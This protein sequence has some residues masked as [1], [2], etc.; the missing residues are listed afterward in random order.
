MITVG[1][2]DFI[3]TTY[4]E[5]VIAIFTMILSC[6]IFAYSMNTI[7]SIIKN[8]N[9]SELII[10]RNIHIINSY[11][12]KKNINQKTQGAIRQYLE[13]YWKEESNRDSKSEEKIINQ[14]S[15]NLKQILQFESNNIIFKKSSI[16]R[17]NFSSDLK[18][19]IIPLIKEHRATP[20]ELICTENNEDDCSIY[21]LEKGSVE[22]VLLASS[23]NINQNKSNIVLSVGQSFGEIS[24]F[25]GKPRCMSIK[26][27]EFTTLLYIKRVDFLQIVK[28][29]PE[30]YE[31]FC[32]IKDN[33]DL[34]RQYSKL[35]IQCLSCKQLGHIVKDCPQ[36][37]FVHNQNK[38]RYQFLLC[39]LQE[40]KKQSR[41]LSQKF[42]TILNNQLIK[43]NAITLQTNYEIVEAYSSQSQTDY[44]TNEMHSPQSATD[45]QIKFQLDFD[46]LNENIT[47]VESPLKYLQRKAELNNTKTKSFTQFEDQKDIKIIEENM[48]SPF[49]Q[50][51]KNYLLQQTKENK[52]LINSQQEQYKELG[53]SD[54][55]LE[56]Q[57]DDNK[58]KQVQNLNKGI[59]LNKDY[60]FSTSKSSKIE[61][62]G[63]KLSNNIEKSFTLGSLQTNGKES[64]RKMKT[65]SDIQ[66]LNFI[67]NQITQLFLNENISNKYY[68]FNQSASI[69]S[70]QKQQE[71]KQYEKKFSNLKLNQTQTTDKMQQDL[72]QI[73]N[74][75]LSKNIQNEILFQDG[76][77]VAKNFLF[78]FPKNNIENLI[79]QI[80]KKQLK[81]T[82]NIK[83]PLETSLS[84]C[85]KSSIIFRKKK[86]STDNSGQN[87]LLQEDKERK[88]SKFWEN[89]FIYSDDLK[90]VKYL[91]NQE[92]FQAN[93]SLNQ[94]QKQ[95][96]KIQNKSILHTEQQISL[97]ESQLK[98]CSFSQ[99]QQELNKQD[100]LD[101]SISYLFKD[102]DFI[103]K[104]K[105]C[106]EY[107]IQNKCS[108][109]STFNINLLDQNNECLQNSINTDNKKLR[110]LQIDTN[111]IN[112]VLI[113]KNLVN[114]DFKQAYTRYF[115][116]SKMCNLENENEFQQQ[117]L[118]THIFQN[119]KFDLAKK[120]NINDL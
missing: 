94:T 15:E 104:K 51:Q 119:N 99:N 54:I 75:P 35:N 108:E 57:D 9:E 64:I 48:K 7:G 68:E 59:L 88:K 39:P 42:Q 4:L 69:K 90:S 120:Q 95:F 105:L 101:Q 56:I 117:G 96:N 8:F 52:D 33:I 112:N 21:F 46:N 84:N 24:F 25:T 81:K 66:K 103:K 102:Q 74:N 19:K 31:R 116:D 107:N 106:E 76:F 60:N 82:Q 34:Y 1:Y 37:H 30:D 45:R 22:I 83:K 40:R 13:Y 5:K 61:I 58:L 41:K 23:S 80:L 47:S 71:Q 110:S 98:Y 109:V 43:A 17:N 55:Q 20:D 38:I 85:K 53:H 29:F 16:F 72:L 113:I 63:S 44:Q 89:Q 26:S 49:Y 12:Y 2:G 11:M 79:R 115:T 14:L 6:C 78:Y 10:K 86:D 62:K 93:S 92:S 27:L 77:D 36:I 28:Y 100:N 67:L 50:N 73:I 111:K 87:P 32:F 3:P 65:Q 18:Q 70:N 91:E 114:Q 97:D 118:I